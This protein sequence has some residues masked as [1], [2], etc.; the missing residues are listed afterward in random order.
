MLR[1]ELELGQPLEMAE[2]IMLH[3]GLEALKDLLKLQFSHDDLARLETGLY[4]LLK[5]NGVSL[6]P[7]VE[8]KA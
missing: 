4:A 7:L 6:R 1:I 2:S 5:D 3:E 8:V